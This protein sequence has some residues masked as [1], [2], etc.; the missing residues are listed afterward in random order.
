[1]FSLIGARAFSARGAAAA[2]GAG[3]FA[4][5]FGEAAFAFPADFVRAA[6][7][8][9][10]FVAVFAAFRAAVFTRVFFAALRAGGRF[11]A[12]VVAARFV[13]RVRLRVAIG[14]TSARNRR[15][16][17]DRESCAAW[18]RGQPDAAEPAGRVISAA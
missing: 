8:A 2:F 10:R 4:A 5:T 18:R 14:R 6:L 11:A 7:R 16:Q 13:E 17:R 1:M 15:N 12:R 9:G 3:R